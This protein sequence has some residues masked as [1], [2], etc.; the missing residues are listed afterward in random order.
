MSRGQSEMELE[1]HLGEELCDDQSGRATCN[2]SN[3]K[4]LLL[5]PFLKKLSKL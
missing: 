5:S 1:L 4:P 3:V 2:L